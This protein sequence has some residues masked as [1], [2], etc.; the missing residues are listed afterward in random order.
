VGVPAGLPPG[1]GQLSAVEPAEM[2]SAPP[3]SPAEM[4]VPT[5][6]PSPTS[7]APEQEGVVAAVRPG[8]APAGAAMAEEGM[9][10]AHL[11]PRSL[12]RRCRRLPTIVARANCRH[13]LPSSAR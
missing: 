5:D 12:T 10:E 1:A 9:E 4:P 7:P 8:A 11:A 2:G 6:V 3:S 13:V